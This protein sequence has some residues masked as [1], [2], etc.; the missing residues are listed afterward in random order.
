MSLL[1]SL[2]GNEVCFAEKNGSFSFFFF[3][4][5][6]HSTKKI[7]MKRITC[8]CLELHIE[9]KNESFS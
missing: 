5:R 2:Q 1:A 6:K 7:S 8:R 4:E 9:I 3:F